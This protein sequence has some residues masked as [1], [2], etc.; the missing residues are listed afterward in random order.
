MPKKILLILFLFGCIS[1][2]A[3]IENS[4]FRRIAISIQKDSVRFDSVPINPVDFKIFDQTKKL[5]QASDYK[6]DFSNALLIINSKKH[7]QI[8]IEYFRF[9]EFVTKIYTP[10][11]ENLILEET[12]KDPVYR[13]KTSNKK[14]NVQLFEGLKTRGFI[15]RGVTSGNNQNAVTNS[16]L[17]P[18]PLAY[19]RY[20]CRYQSASARH[21]LPAR[22]GWREHASWFP[23]NSSESPHQAAEQ[24]FYPR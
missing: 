17:E 14:E 5:I 13:F 18:L 10:Y 24:R 8:T 4:T 9:P 21:A 11:S 22:S 12:S 19:G 2:Q 1:A 16:A 15:A 7:P 23:A 6:V 20:S 3:Q